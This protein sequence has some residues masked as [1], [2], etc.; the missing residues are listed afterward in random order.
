MNKRILIAVIL[1]VV[2]VAAATVGIVLD[3]AASPAAALP[4]QDYQLLLTELCTKNET[5]LCDNRGKYPDYLEL[6]NLGEDV[7]LAGCT[8]TDGN[9]TSQPLGNFYIPAGGYRVI[10]LADELTGFGLSASGG[11]CIQLLDPAGN[12]IFQTNTTNLNADQVMVYDAGRYTVSDL[13]SP[14]FANDDAGRQAFRT[15][16]R[17][18]SALVINE[19][20]VQN[21]S[22]L[23]D[24]NG[25]FCDVVE[26]RNTGS[27]PVLLSSFCLSDNAANRFRFRLPERYLQPG[28]LVLVFCDGQNYVN[29]NGE[30]HASFA[31]GPEE[32]AVLTAADGSFAAVT[33]GYFGPDVS[34]ARDAEGN[35][36]GAGVSLGYAND[37]NG[38]VQF[39]QSRQAADS[40][41]VISEVLL[42][43]AGVPYNGSFLDAVEL[44]NRSTRPIRTNGWYLTDSSDPFAYAIPE[45]TLQPGECLVVVCGPDTTGFSLSRT[46][47]LKLMN[48]Q[49]L[50]ASTVFCSMSPDG[51]SIC[52]IDS[53][54]SCDA[55][56]LGFANTEEGQQAFLAAQLPK[57]L[58]ISEVMTNNDT[59]LRGPYGNTCDWVE[60]YNAGAESIQLADYTL[61]DS[62]EL[63]HRYAL[64][65]QLLAP[66]Q[67]CVLFFARDSVDLLKDYPVLPGNL[68]AQGEALYL[69]RNGRVEDWVSVPALNTDMS[70][71]RYEGRFLELSKPTPEKANVAPAAICAAPVALTAQG[72][73]D[74]VEY[75]DI[76]L[77]GEGTIYYTTDASRPNRWDKVYNGPIRVSKT[78]VIRAMCVAPGKKNSPV[79][80][81]TYLLNENDHLPVVTIVTDPANFFSEATG[82]YVYGPSY[83]P[84]VPYRGANFWQDW[85]REITLSLFEPDGTGFTAPCGVTIYGAFSRYQRKKSLAFHF[86]GKY[87]ASEL[88]YP[89]FGD[90][91]VS[92]YESFILRAGGQDSFRARIRDEMITSL[93]A[94]YTDIVVQKYR[95]AV[96]YIN[97][98]YYGLHFIRE[99]INEHF[100]AANFNVPA[101]TVTLGRD[102]ASDVALYQQLE[103]FAE[104]HDLRVKENYE[105]LAAMMNI[106][107]YM[108]YIIAQI[109][110][111][112]TDNSNVRFFTAEGIPWHWILYDT[113]LGL[114]YTDYNAVAGHLNPD[115]TG[116][117]NAVST[118]IITAL[119][120]VPEFKEAFL[121]RLA[122]QLDTIWTPEVM[123][124]RINAMVAEIAPD[125][126]KDLIRWNTSRQQWEH[127]LEHLRFYID[128]RYEQLIP[129]IQNFFDLTDQQM[130]GYGFRLAD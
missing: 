83:E 90:E 26:L 53:G 47:T 113:D 128:N 80:D 75:L 34:L 12:I 67:Y 63:L 62:A 124:A 29:Q 89:L 65:E 105:Q 32:Q 86:R 70:Y 36:A 30:I 31:F 52:L 2:M 118:D 103:D 82:I 77:E 112:N 13:P 15:G 101:D 107:Q 119:L 16:S 123:H 79:T 71:G 55:S 109:C 24:G 6:H 44:T 41:L 54:Y 102:N 88:N 125:M 19:V 114:F 21:D 68:S 37:E 9:V 78:T 4:P 49:R 20:L 120:K 58:Q 87:G 57:G 106:D 110:I 84:E 27:T 22:S 116:A 14:G 129:Q 45:Q 96:L 56:S 121:H 69:S 97:G 18:E 50:F 43:S 17:Q 61:S 73:Y 126:P 115:G 48:P 94:E 95:P 5:V 81:L 46:D 35:Y 38:I 66:G 28:E 33:P 92:I 98:Q 122:W 3:I 76:V 111:G 72:R 99:K 85:E 104:S 11:D 8:L 74:G 108:D 100:V 39:T 10:F 23:S 64:P 93:A 117:M 130:V 40:T 51:Q 60:L 42:S 127:H 1:A 25:L 91:G 59:Y 7:N